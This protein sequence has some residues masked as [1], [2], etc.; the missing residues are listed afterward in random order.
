M[1]PAATPFARDLDAGVRALVLDR[2]HHACVRCGL[3][4]GDEAIWPRS[5]GGSRGPENLILLCGSRKTGCTRWIGVHSK[6][7][8]L[9]GWLLTPG[10]DP[11]DKPVVYASSGGFTEYWLTADGGRETE[12]PRER[13]A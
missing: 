9:Y 10:E 3:A 11:L 1:S 13:A 6:R 12:P 7:A 4:V 2:D 5:P 8:L